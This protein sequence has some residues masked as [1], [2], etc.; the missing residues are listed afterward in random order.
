MFDIPEKDKVLQ[1]VYHNLSEVEHG[2][3]HTRTQLQ[4][5]REE[6]DTRT[7]AIMHLEHAVE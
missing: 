1:S 2:L 7:H 6:V 5:A 3:N 4:V